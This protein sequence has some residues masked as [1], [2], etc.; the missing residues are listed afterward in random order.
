MIKLLRGQALSQVLR[1]SAIIAGQF[2]EHMTIG[3]VVVQKLDEKNTLL[4]FTESEDIEK[5]CNTL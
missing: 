4:V 1:T 2:H 5:M 3:T